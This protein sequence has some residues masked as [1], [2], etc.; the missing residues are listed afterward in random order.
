[1][2][3]KVD[4]LLF[5]GAGE[6]AWFITEKIASKEVSALYSIVLVFLEV[7]DLMA[8]FFRI[9]ET[10]VVS[11]GTDLIGDWYFGSFSLSSVILIF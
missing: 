10:T 6:G 1:M 3:P 2:P 4:V 9:D 7:G 11:D 8:D 5:V